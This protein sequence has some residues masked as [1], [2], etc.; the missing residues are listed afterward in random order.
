MDS[1]AG[2][3]AHVKIGETHGDKAAPGEQHVPFIQEAHAAPGGV[4]RASEGRARKAI[5]LASSEM[6]QRMARA[7]VERK[8]RDIH[9]KDKR[10]NPDAEMAVEKESLHRVVP[11]KQDEHKRKIEKITVDILENERKRRLSGIF[12]ARFTNRASRRIKQKSRYKAF[13]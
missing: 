11:E 1:A 5:E 6:A 9:R 2:H 3:Q 4:A 12:A 7:R 8:Q 10:P 13:R